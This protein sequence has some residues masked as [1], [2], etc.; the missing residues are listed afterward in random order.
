VARGLTSHR[1]L[2]QHAQAEAQRPP[3]ARLTAEEDVRGDVERGSYGEVLVDR[4]DAGPAC[5]A[6][7]AEPDALAVEVDLSVVHLQRAGERL[8]QRR[9]AGAVVTDHGDDFV[10][11]QLEV[12][13]VECDD[14]AVALD[15][16][17]CLQE[18]LRRVQSRL[19]CVSWS[20]ET[21]RITRIPVTRY[22]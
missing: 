1:A 5:V 17:A 22:W 11:V 10:R 20:T 12:G 9:L 19:R 2:R 6:G 7:R 16:P 8:D 15:E 13:S 4:L 18:R 3:P 14:V 21:A